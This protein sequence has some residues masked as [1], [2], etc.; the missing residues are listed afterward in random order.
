MLFVWLD[1]FD[2]CNCNVQ[3]LLQFQ[4]YHNLLL[5]PIDK[6]LLNMLSL[7]LFIDA[8]SLNGT[9]FCGEKTLSIKNKL[10]IIKFGDKIVNSKWITFKSLLY[11]AFYT[12][13]CKHG[14]TINDGIHHY[15]FRLISLLWWIKPETN[16]SICLYIKINQLKKHIV[17]CIHFIV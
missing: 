11:W 15:L 2:R 12:Q 8:I 16:M 5:H 4:V 17:N 9:F 6:R 3:H 1:H 7:L 13:N 10:K 14:W